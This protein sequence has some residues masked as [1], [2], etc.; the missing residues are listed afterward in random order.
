[1]SDLNPVVAVTINKTT[2]AVTRAGFG[3]PG[4]I[5]EFDADL[6]TTAFSRAR[7]YATL[8]EASDD[9][10]PDAVIDA[11]TKIFS[12][13]PRPSKVLVGRID[14]GDADTGESLDAIQNENKDWYAYTVV[15]IRSGSFT[16]STDLITGNVVTVSV[17]GSAASAVTFATDHA[18]TMAAIE[19]AIETLLGADAVA[20]TAGDVMSITQTGADINSISVSITG[21][22]SVPTVT[23]AYELDSTVVKD[24]AEW[25]ETQDKIYFI[26]GDADASVCD[27]TSTTDLFYELK[28]LGYE[29]TAGT[30]TGTPANYIGSAWQGKCLPKD[31]GSQTWAY[32][33]LTGVVADDLTSAQVNAII[34]KNGNVYTT[35][36]G[37][38]CTRYGKVFSGEYVDVVRGIDWLRARLQEAVFSLLVNTDKVPMSDVGISMVA[39]AVSSVLAAAES[40][41]VLI[42]GSSEITV[43]KYADLTEAQKLARELPV[44]FTAKLEG[45]I[46]FVSITGSVSV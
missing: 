44:S 34:G 32:K 4:V 18:T 22:L 30:Y 40:A 27:S 36:G 28:A 21:G 9:N 42:S 14:S 10:L 11:I 23:Y 24:S 46:H 2:S 41:G 35:I 3:T 1:M 33:Q 12:Q 19:V 6:T 37:V 25:A 26:G 17:N 15:G 45:A 31:P 16:L 5:C 20:T 29:R 38:D 7:T 43:P 8:S 13:N 39:G